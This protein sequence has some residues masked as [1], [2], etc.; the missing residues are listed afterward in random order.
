M[1]PIWI[2][3]KFFCIENGSKTDKSAYFVEF[4]EFGVFFCTCEMTNFQINEFY[5]KNTK[6]CHKKNFFVL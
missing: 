5:V 6:F 2:S 4:C 3:L 1:R